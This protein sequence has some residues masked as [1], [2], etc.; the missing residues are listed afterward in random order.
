MECANHPALKQ[1]T[2]LRYSEEYRDRLVAR[3]RGLTYEQFW[4]LP[5]DIKVDLVA[6]WEATCRIEALQAWEARQQAE[7]ES[8]R[9]AKRKRQG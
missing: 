4:E 7:L 1:R 9:K 6:E 8:R 5:R 3:D 2:A